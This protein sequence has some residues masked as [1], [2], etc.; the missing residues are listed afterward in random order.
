MK[1]LTTLLTLLTLSTSVLA[2]QFAI[3]GG[4]VH[5]IW[6]RDFR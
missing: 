6:P 5:V 3:V 1:R 4:K 2:N